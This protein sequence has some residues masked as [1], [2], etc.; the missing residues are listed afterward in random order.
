M[1]TVTSEEDKGFCRWI[2]F[3]MKVKTA[4]KFMRTESKFVL[5]RNTIND[6][7][8]T[9]RGSVKVGTGKEKDSS[10]KNSEVHT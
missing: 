8:A 4:E 6:S 3:F 2:C 1:R 5:P 7:E 10:I 9:R